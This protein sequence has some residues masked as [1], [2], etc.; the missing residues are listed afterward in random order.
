MFSKQPF[1]KSISAETYEDYDMFTKIF[2][3]YIL[4]LTFEDG[5]Q[6]VVSQR[7]TDFI[8]LLYSLENRLNLYKLLTSVYSMSFFLSYKIFQDHIETTFSAFRNRGGYNDNP[9]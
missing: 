7:K 9:T 3:E 2:K 6:M 1:C 8:G 5:I 4:G